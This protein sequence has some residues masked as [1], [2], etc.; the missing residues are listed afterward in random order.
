MGSLSYDE[1]CCLHLFVCIESN[2]SDFRL[3]E[4]TLASFDRANNIVWVAASEHWQFVQGPV[5]VVVVI[6]PHCR[7]QVDVP[8]ARNFQA[9]RPAILD[10]ELNLLAD[11]V[12]LQLWQIR[13]RLL[14]LSIERRI[15]LHRTLL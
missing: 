8:I 7:V 12:I 11:I 1:S 13:Q 9:R 5:P 15:C 10:H 6:W 2:D 4:V 3:R 14:L